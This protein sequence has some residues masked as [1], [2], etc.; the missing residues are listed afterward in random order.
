MALRKIHWPGEGKAVCGY[1]TDRL[2]LN[3]QEVSCERCKKLLPEVTR[4][5]WDLILDEDHSPPV[6]K[7]KRT[8]KPKPKPAPILPEVIVRRAPRRQDSMLDTFAQVY[9]VER[10]PADPAEYLVSNGP[11]PWSPW[12]GIT[13]GSMIILSLLAWT[14]LTSVYSWWMH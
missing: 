13:I 9:G 14:I 11:S 2:A 12:L 1:T 8:R 10:R 3:A 4:T 5:A 7:P 6:A